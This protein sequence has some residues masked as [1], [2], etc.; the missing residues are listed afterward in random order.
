MPEA[1]GRFRVSLVTVLICVCILGVSGLVA[2]IRSILANR[3]DPSLLKYLG[4]HM[5][6]HCAACGEAYGASFEGRFPARCKLCNQAEARFARKCG[7]CGQVF[8]TNGWWG[9]AQCPNCKGWR[10][11]D[12]F[13]GN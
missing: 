9:R 8:G 3:A 12:R 2:S 1:E 7:S 10:K 6:F 5:W 13:N 11:I 4:N